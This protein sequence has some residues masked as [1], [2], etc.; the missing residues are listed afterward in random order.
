MLYEAPIGLQPI[1]DNAIYKDSTSATPSISD[2]ELRQSDISTTQSTST[3]SVP[4]SSLVKTMNDSITQL[5]SDIVNQGTYSTSAETVVGTYGGATLYRKVFEDS[6][7]GARSISTPGITSAAKIRRLET[8]VKY[9]AYMAAPYYTSS[10]D[11]WNAYYNQS[12]TDPKV[13]FRG[14]GTMMTASST[15]IAILEYTK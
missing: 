5:N 4:S 13:V 3:T 11:W 10:T 1:L 6:G 14:S 15:F 9:N 8:Y 2:P 7:T 12:S